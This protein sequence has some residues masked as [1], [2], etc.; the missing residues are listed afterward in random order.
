MTSRRELAVIDR[1]D[2][3][4]NAVLR[5]WRKAAEFDALQRRLHGEETATPANP[6]TTE[7]PKE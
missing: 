2:R 6:T 5:T 4:A 1:C 3:I 7:T